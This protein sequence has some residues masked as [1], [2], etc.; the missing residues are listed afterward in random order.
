VTRALATLLIVVGLAT[1]AQAWPAS[2]LQCLLR[3]ARRAVPRSLG[4]L[5][6]D[7]EERVIEETRQVPLELS[8]ALAQDLQ[9]GRLQP[10]TLAALEA[11]AGGALDLIRQR[12]VGDGLVRLGGLARI[13]A[14]LAD[15][16]LSAG[17]EGLAPGVAREYYAFVEANLDKIPVV[18]D[19][20]A[21]LELGRSGLAGYWQGLLTRS[22]AQAPVIGSGMLHNGRAI[23]HS[24]IDFRSPVFGVASLSYSR[25]VTA[26]AA[27]WLALW[28][29]VK[30]DLTAR[31]EPLVL[32]PRDG[33]QDPLARATPRPALEARRP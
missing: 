33:A 3:D 12:R 14:D 23:N 13:P 19:D 27:T 9:A 2:L 25:A 28:R 31:P 32:A 11:H 24:L 26:I 1:Q 18:L 6:L 22:R 20:P 17:P 8:R 21:A 29:E 15:P 10:E 30:G 7:R 16:V 5:L 4:R